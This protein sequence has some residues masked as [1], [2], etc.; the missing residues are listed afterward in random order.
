[1]SLPVMP[2]PK[3]QFFT[4]NAPLAG[5]KVY[6]YEA[7]T[8]TPK[9]TYADAEGVTMNSNPVILDSEGRAS[10]YLSGTYKTIVTDSLDVPIFSE[11]NISLMPYTTLAQSEWVLQSLTLTYSSA[12]VFT[13]ASDVTTTFTAGRRVKATVAAGTVYGVVKS[14]SYGASTTTVTLVLDSGALDSGLSG[15]SIG[16]INPTN[17]SLPGLYALP[18]Y[19]TTQRD[20]LTAA[21]GMVIYNTTTARLEGYYGSAWRTLADGSTT[22]TLAGKTL[23]TPTI[24]SFVNAAH[25]HADAAGGG[26]LNATA[27]SGVVTGILGT[28]DATKAIDTVYQ[29][30]TD[31]IV[32]AYAANATNGSGL[33][34]YTDVSNP[35]T[36]ARNA[37]FNRDAT[38]NTD[39]SVITPVK[40]GHYW[41][42]TKTGTTDTPAINVIPIGV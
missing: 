19:T 30:A 7:N 13:V 5:G 22:E 42:I 3:V 12:T 25:T 33:T 27:V 21:A 26:A 34:A 31:L 28:W 24:A 36:T 9:A 15:I 32:I 18:R 23:T 29:A 1:M 11:P 16:I 17:T 40:K 41:K 4:G 6:T 37:M 35:P 20:A 8:S 38:N 10:I 14:S 39:M 2:N